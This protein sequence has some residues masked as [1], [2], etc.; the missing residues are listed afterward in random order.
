MWEDF[1]RNQISH[2]HA[3]MVINV[4]GGILSGDIWGQL[5]PAMAASERDLGIFGCP[6]S[7]CDES[8]ST[9]DTWAGKECVCDGTCEVYVHF[10]RTCASFLRSNPTRLK[11]KGHGQGTH[12]GLEGSMDVHAYYDQL[13]R[14]DRNE[15]IHVS[16]AAEPGNFL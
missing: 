14:D 1:R 11:P 10:L 13:Q 7:S 12:E 15:C 2:A 16:F 6:T 8:N 9:P 3:R 4:H 5:A